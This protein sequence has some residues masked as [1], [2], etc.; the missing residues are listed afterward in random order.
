[1]PIILN[2]SFTN[3][4]R[5]VKVQNFIMA[6]NY[7]KEFVI[8]LADAKPTDANF[9]TI[10]ICK[11][12]HDELHVRICDEKAF[13]LDNQGRYNMFLQMVEEFEARNKKKGTN[14]RPKR[15]Q[16]DQ[17]LNN[18]MQRMTANVEDINDG[19]GD[20]V[21]THIMVEGIAQILC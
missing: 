14:P 5:A 2:N 1:M 10:R 4:Y 8:Q 3:I 11:S 12:M 18:V 7:Q 17:L 21:A 6:W 16:F 13:G 19:A 15:N 20:G 9:L